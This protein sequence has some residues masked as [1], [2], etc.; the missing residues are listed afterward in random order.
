[1]W[2]VFTQAERPTAT[3]GPVRSCH[4]A[5]LEQL[6]PLYNCMRLIISENSSNV[7]TLNVCYGKQRH[8]TATLLMKDFLT[9]DTKIQGKHIRTVC[10]IINLIDMSTNQADESI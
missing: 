7:L 3:C 9:Q 4:S 8:L 10:G 5:T 6:C 1:M 2:I